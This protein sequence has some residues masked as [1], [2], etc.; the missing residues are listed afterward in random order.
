MFVVPLSY[1]NTYSFS[2]KNILIAHSFR[3]K[4]EVK[5]LDFQNFIRFCNVLSVLGIVILVMINYLDFSAFSILNLPKDYWFDIQNHR[6]K[7]TFN[8]TKIN[9]AIFFSKKI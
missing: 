9:L 2:S 5:K 8:Q 1:C 4:R 7:T 3:S 6:L